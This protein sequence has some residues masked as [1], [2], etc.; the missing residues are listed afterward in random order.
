MNI[1]ITAGGTS[2]AIDKVRKITN[3]SKGTLG[4]ELALEASHN[5]KVEKIY[6]LSPFSEIA[7]LDLGK[8]CISKKIEWIQTDSVKSVYDKLKELLTT[9]KIDAVIH[10]MAV[11]D[12]TVDQVFSLEDMVEDLFEYI[13]ANGVFSKDSLSRWFKEGSFQLD[14]SS[15]VSS[16]SSDLYIKLKP[17]EKIISFIKEWSP[18]TTLVGFK[19]LE[20]VTKENLISVGTELMAKNKADYVFANDIRLIRESGHQGYLIKPDGEFLELVGINDI[21]KSII[22]HVVG[23]EH[24]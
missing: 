14:N 21:A 1:V 3:M 4:R 7:E 17:T 23:E 13:Q 24:V 12:Y 16:K 6:F 5:R 8:I 15:K 19:L 22:D 9:K 20:N 10:A 2:E 11:S 18:E